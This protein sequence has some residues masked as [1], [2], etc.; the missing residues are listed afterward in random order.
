[1]PIKGQAIT[2]KRDVSINFGTTGDPAA[3]KLAPIDAYAAVLNKVQE[4]EALYHQNPSAA[5]DLS[6]KSTVFT[7]KLPFQLYAF[8]VTTDYAN[9]TYTFDFTEVRPNVDNEL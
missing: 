5:T 8:D 2:E 3:S 4:L 9:A 7:G 1:M 6:A